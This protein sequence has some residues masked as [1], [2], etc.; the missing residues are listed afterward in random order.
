MNDRIARFIEMQYCASICCVSEQGDPYCFICY[1]AFNPTETLLYFKSAGN[2]THSKILRENTSIA[3]TIVSPQFDILRAEGLQ[4]EGTAISPQSQ[5]PTWA[6][7]HYY[8]RFPSALSIQGEIWTVRLNK[9]KFTDNTQG[10][11]KKLIW[12]RN[13]P[14]PSHT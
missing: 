10:F 13:S 4:F 6:D 1:Y 7:L 12:Y 8:K 5:N 3:G 14:N 9:L 11:G 2:T